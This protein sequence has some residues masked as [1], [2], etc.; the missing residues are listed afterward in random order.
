MAALVLQM[1]TIRHVDVGEDPATNFHKFGRGPDLARGRCVYMTVNVRNVYNWDGAL[2]LQ[3][4]SE[5]VSRYNHCGMKRDVFG[6]PTFIWL[7]L[8]AVLG[9]LTDLGALSGS[10]RQEMALFLWSQCTTEIYLAVFFGMPVYWGNAG[11]PKRIKSSVRDLISLA[12]CLSNARFPVS[13]IL[14]RDA[15]LRLAPSIFWQESSQLP[16]A[17]RI[18]RATTRTIAEVDANSFHLLDSQIHSSDDVDSRGDRNSRSA[19]I[20][21]L[22]LLLEGTLTDW[23]KEWFAAGSP[24]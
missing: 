16:E 24:P 2:R 19:C 6:E 21:K 10:S 23:L 8:G 14:S 1:L 5:M 18:N 9:P 22:S 13:E 20:L 7:M 11:L 12:S 15:C 3:D 4:T 17:A